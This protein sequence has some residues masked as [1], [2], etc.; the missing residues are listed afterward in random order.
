MISNKKNLKKTS[1]LWSSDYSHQFVRFFIREHNELVASAMQVRMILLYVDGD[2][3]WLKVS[4]HHSQS[5]EGRHV[6]GFMVRL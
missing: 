6:N 2:K 5:F 4:T 3:N 1:N